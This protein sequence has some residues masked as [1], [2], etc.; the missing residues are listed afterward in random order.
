MERQ[1]EQL[2]KFFLQ[3]HFCQGALDPKL[4]TRRK[5]LANVFTDSRA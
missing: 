5:A 1:H 2:P 4:R 3:A